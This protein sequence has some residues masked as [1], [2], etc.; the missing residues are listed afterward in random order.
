[1]N[2]LFREDLLH[3][4]W[5]TKNFQAQDLKTTDNAPINILEF[6][7]YNTDSGA[8]FQNARVKIGD[9]LWAGSVEMHVY[10][11]D[12][13]KHNH[14][15]D[16]AYKNVV[17]HV[18]YEADIPIFRTNAAGEFTTEKLPCLELK[19]RLSAKIC[20]R[21]WQLMHNTDWVACQNHLGQI[22]EIIQKM[23]LERLVSERLEEKA[24]QIEAVL[25]E[26]TNDWEETFYQFIARYLGV[27]VNSEPM[28]WL[29]KSLPNKILAKHK[30]NRFQL[31]ALLFGQAGFLENTAFADAYPQQLTKEYQFLKHKYQLQ[32]LPV[33]A[34]RFSK[35]RPP[36]FPT[37]RLAQLAELAHISQSLF[38]KI[39]EI[40]DLE[41]LKKLFSVQVS[42]YWQTHFVIDKPS[43]VAR[44]KHL[45]TETIDLLLINVVVPFLFHYGNTRQ[46]YAYSERALAFLAQIAAEKNSF[47]EN[48]QKAG[49][50]AQNAQES[51]ALLQLKKQYCTPLKCL[52]CAFGHAI[53]KD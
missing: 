44:E 14:H 38:S 13:L 26:N 39:L 36:N 51:Q 34:W 29:A 2:R 45:G 21:Y 48:W 15:Q 9:Y 47:T 19:N 20:E 25:K 18:V 22:P 37:I 10:S 7:N 53:L 33:V 41:T 11:S 23:W 32:S 3:Y 12:W 27:K 16:A 6:G 5:R 8:D 49:I 1:M 30:N 46:D 35:L 40:R 42:E 31:E 52:S 17:L 28:Q 24:L 4:A 43:T 50:R